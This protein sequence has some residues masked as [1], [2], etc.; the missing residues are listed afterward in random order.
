MKMTRSKTMANSTPKF[1]FL[2]MCMWS[3]LSATYR[4]RGHFGVED[5]LIPLVAQLQGPMLIW[6]A[7]IPAIPVADVAGCVD[8][9]ASHEKLPAS[10]LVA[11]AGVHV[12]VRALSLR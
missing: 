2:A 10:V 8:G 7:V 6:N 3:G 11:A 12:T 5:Y 4:P 1:L 9:L